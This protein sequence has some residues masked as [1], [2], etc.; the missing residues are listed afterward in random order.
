MWNLKGYARSD[1]SPGENTEEKGLSN[2]LDVGSVAAINSMNS[3]AKARKEGAVL[4]KEAQIRIAAWEA[5]KEQ[6]S[7]GSDI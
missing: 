1:F 2:P 5:W 3:I 6:N 4:E 7:A